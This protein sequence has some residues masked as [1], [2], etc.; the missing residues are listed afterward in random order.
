MKILIVLILLY[1]NLFSL[2]D[3]QED[4][5][6]FSYN[7]GR[8]IKAKDGMTF[9]NTLAS[10]I[11]T[12][13]SAGKFIIGDKDK[14]LK[15]CSLGPY[16]IRLKTAKWIINKDKFLYRHFNKFSDDRLVTLLL[17]KREFGALI[18]G[19]LL[20]YWYNTALDRNIKHP[21]FYAVSRYNGG[22]HNYKYVNRIRKNI[23]IIRRI[24]R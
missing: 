13:S 23:K 14:R 9:E 2:E 3:Y 17:T 19:S 1:S 12:E 24:L 18:A 8:Y 21:W 20:K 22:V 15:N 5:I 11:Y 4:N 16:Q 6:R 10:I 7:I